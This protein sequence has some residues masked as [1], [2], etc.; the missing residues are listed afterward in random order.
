MAKRD[1]YQLMVESEVA[2]TFDNKYPD[3]T[4]FPINTFTPSVK[5]LP[6]KLTENDVLKLYALVFSYYNSFELYDDLTL[7]LNDVEYIS[8]T[9][10]NFEKTLKLYSKAD[11]DK[12]F[13]QQ[14]KR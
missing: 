8:N 4:T 7:W 14:I 9:D 1:K 3:L 2:D 10:D 11:L 12:W 13:M 6:R 5:Y